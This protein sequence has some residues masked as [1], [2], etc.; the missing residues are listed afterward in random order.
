MAL[1]SSKKQEVTNTTNTTYAPVEVT[2]TVGPTVSESQSSFTSWKNTEIA[3]SMNTVGSYNRSIS[4]S[5]PVL[6]AGAGSES[7]MRGS[8]LDLGGFFDAPQT[9]ATAAPGMPIWQKIALGLAVA[10]VAFKL[11]RR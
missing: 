2:T 11:F 9:S 4:V 6:V 10:F 3:D 8:G 5:N 1:F 7:L